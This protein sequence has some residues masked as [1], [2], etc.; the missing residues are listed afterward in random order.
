MNCQFAAIPLDPAAAERPPTS[1]RLVRVPS[2]LMP[3]MLTDPV[4]ESSVYKNFP[5]ALMAIS[6]L[7]LPEGLIPTSVPPTGVSAPFFEIKKPE[8]VAD[9]AFDVYTNCPLGVTTFQHVA[10]ARVGTPRLMGVS[11]PFVPTAYDEMAEAFVP[12][13]GPV[14]ATRAALLGANVTANTPGSALA[15]TTIGARVPSSWTWNASILLVS[16]SVTRRNWPSGLNDNEAGPEFAVLRKASECEIGLSFPSLLRLKPLTLLLAP[17]LTTLHEVGILS[18]SNGR[19]ASAR[20]R[21]HEFEIRTLN[22][23]YRNVAATCVHSKEER[24]VLA[25]S[26]GTLRS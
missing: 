24:M 21:V 6:R 13:A 9:P 1:P 23:E 8:I 5:S 15:L 18:H 11:L 2:S 12:P 14:S 22:P 26:K 20:H 4:P 10:A 7:V 25:K 3:K 19:G 16:F 17:S